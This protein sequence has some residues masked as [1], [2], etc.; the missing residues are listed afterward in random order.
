MRDDPKE[1]PGDSQGHEEPASP[2]SEW[3]T[4]PP[5]S[6]PCKITRDGS[7]IESREDK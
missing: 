7:D 4:P 1:I 5:P 2:D 6:D 3:D